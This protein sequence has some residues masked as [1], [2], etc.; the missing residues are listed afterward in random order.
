MVPMATLPGLAGATGGPTANISR[1]AK[2]AIVVRLLLNEGADIPLEE[3]PEELQVE[4]TQQ[5]GAMRLID[6]D[7]L[8]SVVSE[9]AEELDSVGLSFPGGIAGALDAL[10]GRISKHTAARL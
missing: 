9:F 5:M 8:A 4:L 3:L 10:D 6:R 1:K 7:T 2:A